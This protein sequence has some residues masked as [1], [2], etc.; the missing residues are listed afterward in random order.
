MAE[1]L[2]T[3]RELGLDKSDRDIHTIARKLHM[4]ITGRMP[5]QGR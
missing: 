4:A 2:A 5:E 1:G 3:I